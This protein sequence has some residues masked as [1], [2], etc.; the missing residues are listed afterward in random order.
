[1]VGTVALAT[2]PGGGNQRHAIGDLWLV[3]G[4]Y[5]GPN[6]Y[7]A[8]GDPVTAADFGFGSQTLAELL[9]MDVA[10]GTEFGTYDSTNGKIRLFTADGVEVAGGA[11]ASTQVYRFIALIA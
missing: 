6:P 2:K 10:G 11:N 3:H 1:M 7:T 4:T 9:L 8:L 5:T